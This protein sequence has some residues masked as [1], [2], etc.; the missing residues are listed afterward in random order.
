MLA[1]VIVAGR[2]YTVHVSYKANF[3]I[4]IKNNSIGYRSIQSKQ[5][6]YKCVYMAYRY[7]RYTCVMPACILNSNV[8]III[9]K[10]RYEMFAVEPDRSQPVMKS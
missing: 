5:H 1:C 6:M 9:E 4:I 10:L 8:E 7:A 3:T 2:Q